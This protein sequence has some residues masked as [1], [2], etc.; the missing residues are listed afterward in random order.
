L[1]LDVFLLAR[2]GYKSQSLLLL[3]QAGPENIPPLRSYVVTG[4]LSSS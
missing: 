4:D 2:N 3:D 1:D